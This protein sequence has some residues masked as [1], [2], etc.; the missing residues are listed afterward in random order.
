MQKTRPSPLLNTALPPS[1]RK[2]RLELARE[3]AH[4]DGAAG[5][6]YIIVA[7]LDSD[8]R[9]D[10]H[11]WKQHR[12]A[13]RVVRERPDGDTRLGHLLHKPGGSWAFHYDITQDA[14]DEAGHHFSNER[15]APGEYVSLHEEGALHT[16]RIVTVERL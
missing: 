7:P 11:A 8:G 16:F 2:I 14:P 5:I 1:F 3:A 9:I 12:E 6:A 10:A 13:C 15:F 4:P